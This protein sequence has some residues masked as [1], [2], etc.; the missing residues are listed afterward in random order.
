MSNVYQEFHC[1]HCP[2]I[3]ITDYQAEPGHCGAP[4]RYG[5]VL[6]PTGDPTELRVHV[7]RLK[8]APDLSWQLPGSPLAVYELWQLRPTRLHG[9]RFGWL[10]ERATV[11]EWRMPTGVAI[12]RG[13]AVDRDT[14]IKMM[15][16]AY[17]G[18]IHAAAHIAALGSALLPAQ[19]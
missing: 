5:K 14:A 12:E 17:E 18:G 6:L 19:P 10:A 2:E 3:E 13:F 1:Q 4:M 15:W 9:E 11:W 8:R 7:I 16:I